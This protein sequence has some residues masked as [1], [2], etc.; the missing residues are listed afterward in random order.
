MM[1]IG[2]P[3]DPA[4]R[5]RAMLAYGDG[6]TIESKIDYFRRWANEMAAIDLKLAVLLRDLQHAHEDLRQ[7]C[8]EVLD[9]EGR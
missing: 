3:P 8:K 5:R 2:P 1:P 9:K 4:A 6:P 7:F